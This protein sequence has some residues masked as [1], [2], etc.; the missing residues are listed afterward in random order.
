MTRTTAVVIL[1]TTWTLAVPLWAAG[2]VDAEPGITV[3]ELVGF[4]HLMLFVF[5]LGADVGV[6]ICAQGAVK[7][8]LAP[9]QRLRTAGLMASIELA[10][11]VSASLM[12]TVGGILT[13]YVGLEHP[14]WQI[15]GIILLGPV[16]LALVLASYFRDGTPFGATATRLD[17]WMRGL[18]MVAVPVSVAY[19]SL[20]GRLASAPYVAWK[21][22]I[23]AMLMLLGLLMR[24]ALGPFTEGLRTLAALGGSAAVE[25]AMAQSVARARP[26]VFAIW[27]GLALAAFLGITKPGAPEEDLERETSPGSVS[28]EWRSAAPVSASVSDGAVRWARA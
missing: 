9:D 12:L 13:E 27:A 25:A 7:P 22:L 16:W 24:R 26:Y 21:L 15:A 10:P 2:A 4:L 1:L 19:A 3:R 17:V 8:G 6:F 14:P 5:W 11:R 23:F 20:T 18:L 28:L